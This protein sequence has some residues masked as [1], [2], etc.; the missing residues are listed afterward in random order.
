M[1]PAHGYFNVAN[2]LLEG[3]HGSI[4]E[5]VHDMSSLNCGTSYF[6]AAKITWY[7]LNDKFYA[8]DGYLLLQAL[9]SYIVRA[10]ICASFTE[11]VYASFAL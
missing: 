8:F 10:K 4:F 5:A 1:E 9:S 2:D 7:R 3:R 6:I 11:S